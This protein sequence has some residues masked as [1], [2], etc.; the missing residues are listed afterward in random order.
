MRLVDEDGT[1]LGEI[2]QVKHREHWDDDGNCP[3]DIYEVIVK[4]PEWQT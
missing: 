1:D 3:V 2:L 4:S